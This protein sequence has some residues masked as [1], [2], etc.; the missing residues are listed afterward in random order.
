LKA[1]A[2]FLATLLL[3][4]TVGV[5]FN[6]TAI[7][8]R[9]FDPLPEPDGKVQRNP[10]FAAMAA[11]AAP[12]GIDAT[13]LQDLLRSRHLALPNN[14]LFR[15]PAHSLDFLL[16]G[17][18]SLVWNNSLDVVESLTG[19]RVGMV[20]YESLAANPKLAQAAHVLAT[21][22]LKPDGALVL[23]FSDWNWERNPDAEQ[24]VPEGKQLESFRDKTVL[25]EFLK[26][27]RDARWFSPRSVQMFSQWTTDE[28]ERL[29]GRYA[30]LGLP[31]L[32]LYARKVEPE[33]APL[34]YAKKQENVPKQGSAAEFQFGPE[35]LF[36]HRPN[37]PRR[38][39]NTALAPDL[40]WAQSPHVARNAQAF[41]AL[42]ARKMVVIP[43]NTG[44]GANRMRALQQVHFPQAP[45]LDLALPV[46]AGWKLPFEPADS[47]SHLT[48][49]GTVVSSFVLGSLLAQQK[50]ESVR[51][52]LATVELPAD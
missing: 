42:S 22:F 17:D 52:R 18:S 24:R 15:Q 10:E 33:W 13:Q 21:H 23:C 43:M 50:E 20:G 1:G 3:A 31:D 48:G 2:W 25:L 47:T 14:R 44:V 38:V 16:F 45:V 28:G 51:A 30:R 26:A 37:S 8:D 29:F 34:L 49:V 40:A 5:A 7:H 4:A 12:L 11:V 36:L 46:P 6:A 9:W 35:S 27:E 41:A 39:P 19:K 32:P